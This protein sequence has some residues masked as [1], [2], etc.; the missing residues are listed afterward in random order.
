MTQIAQDKKL[1][2]TYLLI[3]IQHLPDAP[4]APG[5]EVYTNLLMNRDMYLPDYDFPVEDRTYL[6]PEDELEINF[7]L[8]F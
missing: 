2:R 3:R 4:D 1:I 5:T 8:T 7:V 6:V